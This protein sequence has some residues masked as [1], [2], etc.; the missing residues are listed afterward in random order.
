MIEHH[1]AEIDG[2]LV[3]WAI[4]PT[5][6]PAR[7]PVLWVHGVP[8]SSDVWGP[9]LEEAGGIAVDLPG[10]GRSGKRADLDHTIDG[11]A[12]FVGRFLDHL[13]IERVRLCCHD[14]GAVA[15][16][17]AAREP[18]RVERLVAIDVVPFVE[19]FRWHWAARRWRTRVVGELAMGTTGPLLLRRFT[20]NDKAWSDQVMRH[21]DQGTQRAILRLYRGADPEVVAAAGEGLDAVTAPALIL[22]GER[23]RYLDPAYAEALA[24][25][26]A[27]AET[28]VEVVS[29]AGHWPWL[30]DPAVIGRVTAFLQG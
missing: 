27:S 22:W 18:Q 8:D 29:D 16:A 1:E 15:L 19:G 25:R 20:G 21:F 14:W 6:D 2:H 24:R 7:A 23:D 17:W 3:A 10:F 11:Y 26:L 12:T 9:F 5:P 28:T 4:A 30:D 13:G